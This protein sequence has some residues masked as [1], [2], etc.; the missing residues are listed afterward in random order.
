[1][2]FSYGFDLF[3]KQSN[4]DFIDRETNKTHKRDGSELEEREGVAK[5][6]H[7]DSSLD[8]KKNL[9]PSIF[10]SFNFTFNNDSMSKIFDEKKVSLRSPLQDEYEII[11]EMYMEI[12]A[13]FDDKMTETHFSDLVNHDCVEIQET[14]HHLKVLE[15]NTTEKKIIGLV[16]IIFGKD[17]I[18]KSTLFCELEGIYVSKEFRRQGFGELLGK[19]A[20]EQALA[21]QA[22]SIV[23]TSTHKGAPLYAKLGFKPLETSYSQEEWSKR[24]V[25]EKIKTY[26][27]IFKVK[28]RLDLM[29][30]LTSPSIQNKWKDE[31]KSDNVPNKKMSLNFLLD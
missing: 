10:K 8:L 7:Y 28:D 5:R 16:H 17:S 22:S 2:A 11:E 20:I 31:D 29:L 19:Y 24:S 9:A 4:T 25:T 21:N 1:M 14:M 26:E 3:L 27:K 18:Q 6:A 30:D 12:D 23:L 15:F 13:S